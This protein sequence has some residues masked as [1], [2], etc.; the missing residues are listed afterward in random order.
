M[1][2]PVNK[3]LLIS[4]LSLYLVLYLVLDMSLSHELTT[5]LWFASNFMYQ[6]ICAFP[7]QLT[8]L[9]HVR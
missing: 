8:F 1:Q 6:N 3:S 4:P 7:T 5:I 9:P 2:F